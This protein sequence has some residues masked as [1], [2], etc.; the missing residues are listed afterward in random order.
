MTRRRRVLGG[1]WRALCVV[2]I[3]LGVLVVGVAVVV[4]RLGGATPY[5]ILTGSMEPTYPP[6]TLVVVREVDP[7]DI[8]TGDVVTF[9]LRSGEPAVATH[10]VVGTG[11]STV[12][13]EVVLTTKGD[14]NATADAEPVRAVQVRGR[15][16][17]AVPW[18]G[19]VGAALGAPTRQV[20]VYVA[21]GA[22]LLYAAA[23]VV[24]GVR[25]RRAGVT[26]TGGTGGTGDA[27]GRGG[28]HGG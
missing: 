4:P 22:L 1:A 16:W 28:R 17:Y 26:S 19:H 9:Q 23:M 13:G 21:A 7:D 6:G 25:E 5:T 24:A 2:V 11:R 20:L 12:G 10:R 27:A 8:V 15:V 3:A 14:A 18:L